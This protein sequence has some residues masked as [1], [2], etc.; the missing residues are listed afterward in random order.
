MEYSD[1]SKNDKTR[2]VIERTKHSSYSAHPMDFQLCRL[3]HMTKMKYYKI[4]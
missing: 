1:H 4:Y 3:V 2:H